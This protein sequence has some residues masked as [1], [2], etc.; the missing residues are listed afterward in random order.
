MYTKENR[1]RKNL[2]SSFSELSNQALEDLR[3]LG[4]AVV[5]CGPI[6]TGGRG[7]AEENIRII[8]LTITHL[9][10]QGVQVFDQVPYESTLWTLKDQWEGKGNQGYCMPILTDFYLP[11]YKSGYIQKAYFLPGWDSSFGSNWERKVFL[12]LKIEIIDLD[13]GLIEELLRLK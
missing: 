10:S 1:P 2:A 9:K 3:K 5:V 8:E 7:S 6:T 11:L 12:E 13:V 4:K